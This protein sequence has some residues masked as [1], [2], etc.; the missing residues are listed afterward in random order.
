[1]LHR[2]LTIMFSD[3]RGFTSRTSSQI[4]SIRSRVTHWK[5]RLCHPRG[6]FKV[7]LPSTYYTEWSGPTAVWPRPWQIRREWALLE[8]P[9]GV[10]SGPE[11]A[12]FLNFKAIDP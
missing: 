12:L 5:V 9:Y 10:N 7:V 6:S 3:M 4:V 2:T 11:F 1:M 8:R